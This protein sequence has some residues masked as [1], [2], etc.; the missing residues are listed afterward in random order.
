MNGLEAVEI[1]LSEVI[2]EKTNPRFDSEYFKKKYLIEDKNR[3]RLT[4]KLLNDFSFI[5]DGQHGYHEV[6]EHSNIN[7]LT[8][9][10]A[11][12]WFADIVDAEKVAKWVDEKT[13]GL[14]LK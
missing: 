11:K 4:N 10:N 1:K 3:S 7:F 8:A 2:T 6:D 5:T 14:L 9:K 13:S 12:N